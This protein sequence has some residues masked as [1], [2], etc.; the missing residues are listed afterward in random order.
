MISMSLGVFALPF[1][2][3]IVFFF[4]FDGARLQITKV[5]PVVTVYRNSGHD[6]HSCQPMACFV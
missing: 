6:I 4:F 3:M 1:F 2:L 5:N